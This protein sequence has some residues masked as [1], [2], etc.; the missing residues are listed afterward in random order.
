MKKN[1][2]KW[3]VSPILTAAALFALAVPAEAARAASL[4]E[5]TMCQAPAKGATFGSVSI[6]KI[7]TNTY[8]AYVSV[9]NLYSN[10]GYPVYAVMV[11]TKGKMVT[12]CY[13][14]QVGFIDTDAS[15]SGSALTDVIPAN[16]GDTVQFVVG[17]LTSG[18][19]RLR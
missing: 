14:T 17:T 7:D 13:Y 16:G 5:G 4:Y 11:T 9:N 19:I 6:N 3:V 1:L 10:A 8:T 2:I 12:S 18:F 15:G